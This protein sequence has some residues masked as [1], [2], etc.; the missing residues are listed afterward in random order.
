MDCS[1]CGTIEAVVL[2]NSEDGITPVCEKCL[3]DFR[4]KK[5]LLLEL[6]RNE[7]SADWLCQEN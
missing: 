1:Y 6:G 5:G 3:S 7:R 2:V 4:S